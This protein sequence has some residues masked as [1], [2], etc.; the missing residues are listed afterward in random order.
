[1]PADWGLKFEMR[2]QNKYKARKVSYE[3]YTFDSQKE[4]RRYRELK[5]LMCAKKISDLAVK[6]KA[7]SIDFNGVHVCKYT[8]DFEYI[9]CDTGKHVVEDVK[10][11]ETG[12]FKLKKKLMLAAHGIEIKIT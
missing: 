3:G 5:L 10:G 1:M 9:D 2:K 11:M 7:Y 4:Y 6:P 8:P 12:V